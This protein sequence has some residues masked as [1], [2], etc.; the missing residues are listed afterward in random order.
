M[1]RAAG[2]LDGSVLDVTEIDAASNNGVDNIRDLRDETRY[3][4]A[5][6]RKRV[7]IIDEVHMLSI[8]AFNAL[9]KTLEEPPEHVSVHSGYH[10]AAQGTC[11]HSVALS[12]VRFPPDRCGGYCPPAVGCC[13]R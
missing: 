10:R 12:A 13:G 4:P 1:R 3:T 8:G 7:F 11:D 9:L 5:Q 2:I 6:V